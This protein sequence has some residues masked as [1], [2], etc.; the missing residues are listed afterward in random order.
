MKQWFSE[1]WYLVII[2]VVVCIIT[3]VIFRFAAKAY[4]N[5][6]RTYK[7]QETEIKR[8]VALKEK[9]VPLTKEKI[10]NGTDEEMLEGVALSIQLPLQKSDSMERD[11]HLLNEQQRLIYILDVF[12][13]DGSVREFMKENGEILTMEITK[14]FTLVGMD[15]FAEKIEHIRKMYDINDEV[16]SFNEKEIENLD[17][18]MQEN[19]ILTTLKLKSAEYIKNNY[20]SFVNL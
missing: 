9:F 8:L 1:Y 16:T 13:S 4:G 12:R 2:L 15:G 5:Y 7:N 20:V 14:A 18:F 19:D 6:R 3:A 17:K 10:L 11:F